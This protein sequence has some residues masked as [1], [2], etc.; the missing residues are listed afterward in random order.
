MALSKSLLAASRYWKEV[1]ENPSR[2]E[3]DKKEA[4]ERLTRI[5]M[6]H[7]VANKQERVR[8]LVKQVRKLESEIQVLIDLL[9]PET[10]VAYL[11]DKLQ[12]QRSVRDKFT[13]K[14]SETVSAN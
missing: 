2:T 9:P 7:A 4:A 6:T 12:K 10:R 11:K 8:I 14:E 13:P 1:L 5:G 3:D